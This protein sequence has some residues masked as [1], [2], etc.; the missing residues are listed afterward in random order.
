MIIVRFFDR[1]LNLLSWIV[2]AV[3]IVYAVIRWFR[4][5]WIPAEANGWMGIV[6]PVLLAGAVGYITNW[7]ALLFLFRPYNPHFFGLI[8]GIIPR[9]KGKMAIS[10]GKMVG[11]KLLKPEAIVAEMELEVKAFISDKKRMA[12]LRDALQNLLVEHEE[13]IVDFAL[14]HIESQVFEI[15][16]SVATDETWSKIWD[17]G[18]LPRV[19]SENSRQFIVDKFTEVLRD[20]ADGMINALREELREYLWK[21]L[22]RPLVPTTMIVNAVMDGFA[23]KKSISKRLFEWLGRDST[24][25]RLK[26]NL[27]CYADKLNDWM[28]G[29]EGRQIMSGVVRELKVRGKRYL[30]TYLREKVPGFIDKAFSSDTLQT[31]LEEKILPMVGEHLA[32]L[33]SDN[34]QAIL[35][36]LRLEKRVADAVNGMSVEDFHKTL[37][38]FMAENF[39]AIQ[40]MGFVFGGLAG[41]LLLVLP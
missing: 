14:P 30:R 11:G 4:P 39:C 19:R 21:K 9:Q 8:H 36:H 25:E 26:S 24:L 3:Q 33:I 23:D 1:V 32:K 12:K 16:E 41:L 2:V 17:E 6:M 20:N 10:M 38:E 31:H 18:I 5:E 27:L 34:K 15:I 29:D 13:E 28:K 37:N 22:D 7:V 40:V 35:D